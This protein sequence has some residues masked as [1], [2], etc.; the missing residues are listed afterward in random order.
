MSATM[1]ATATIAVCVMLTL[2][3]FVIDGWSILRAR[4]TALEVLRHD[5]L[6]DPLQDPI[7]PDVR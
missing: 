7:D 2:L 6:Q 4:R 1:S 5:P 3:V